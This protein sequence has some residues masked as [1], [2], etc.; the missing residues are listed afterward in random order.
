MRRF[1]GND[2]YRPV[3]VKR[4]TGTTTVY[5]LK[6]PRNSTIPTRPATPTQPHPTPTNGK[7]T[8]LKRAR[9]TGWVSDGAKIGY[10]T[11]ITGDTRIHHK[12]RVTGKTVL[13]N[14]TVEQFATVKNSNLTES[15][16]GEHVTIE[17]STLNGS[18]ITHSMTGGRETHWRGEAS[19]QTYRVG[20]V[21]SQLADTTVEDARIIDSTLTGC[22][23]AGNATVENSELYDSHLSGTCELDNVTGLE[24]TIKDAAII[25]D[26]DLPDRVTVGGQ[27][28]IFS[29]KDIVALVSPDGKAVV[30]VYRR[31]PHQ[32]GRGVEVQN[33]QKVAWEG[34]EES[35]TSAE[36]SIL[37]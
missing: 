34:L 9:K 21:R 24:V 26:V 23:V 27:A 16:I 11:R 25:S 1:K 4:G 17:G 10:R 20:A 33:P 13:D 12:T 15:F 37:H 36:R 7:R 3:K 30:T 14:T 35:I 29:P 32:R 2:D 28:Y 31:N 19:Y 5:T 6:N 22:V 8:L 18:T